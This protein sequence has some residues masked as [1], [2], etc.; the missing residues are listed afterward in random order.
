[1][2][3]PSTPY[4]PVIF[5]DE[6]VALNL[7]GYRTPTRAIANIAVPYA[8]NIES[9]NDHNKWRDQQIQVLLDARFN[10]KRKDEL[11]RGILPS[12]ITFTARNTSSRKLNA[13]HG[14]VAVTNEGRKLIA[15]RLD[16]RKLQ[17]AGLASSSFETPAPPG[18]SVLPPLT[19]E[20]S[21]P[22]DSAMVSL[23]D[24]VQ[25]GYVDRTIL[26]QLVKANAALI[27]IGSGLYEDQIAEYMRGLNALTSSVESI[28]DTSPAQ[29]PTALAA[30]S[31]KILETLLLGLK[32][33]YKIFETLAKNVNQSVSVKQQLLNMEQGKKLPTELASLIKQGPAG[34]RTTA[35]QR[36]FP[37]TSAEKAAKIQGARTWLERIRTGTLPNAFAP[38]PEED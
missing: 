22:Y 15:E 6:A 26:E 19:P 10:N 14:G 21:A 8:S 13:I 3:L 23:A 27:S 18:S 24:S 16:Q 7:Y 31:K 38:I 2:T 25:T 36:I 35:Q 34:V 4:L 5:P 12:S 30:T 20:Q 32:R 17:Y 1:M 29:G 9:G 11:M 33:Q 37:A 28:L